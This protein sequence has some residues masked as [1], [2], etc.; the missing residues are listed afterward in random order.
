MRHRHLDTTG[1]TRAAIDSAIEYG[2]LDDWRELFALVRHDQ[3]LAR[4][5]LRI[6]RL[7]PVEG[8]SALARTL[9]LSLW[10]AL[11]QPPEGFFAGV[12]GV[13]T[14]CAEIGGC[15]C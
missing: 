8:A 6:T 13:C 15:G 14:S 5:V 1:W 9:V 3:K 11:N 2:D 10:P 12:S 7:H 4:E